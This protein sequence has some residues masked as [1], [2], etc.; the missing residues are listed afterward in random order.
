MKLIFQIIFWLAIAFSAVAQQ[1]LKEQ[2]DFA[3][4]LYENENYFDAV[5]E[6]KRLSYFDSLNSYGYESNY[7]IGSSYKYGGFYDNA[8]RYLRTAEKF[9]KDQNEKFQ[10]EVE[11]VKANILR[12]TFEQGLLLL[13]ELEN[14]ITNTSQLDE[15]NYWRGWAYMLSDQWER[16]SLHFSRIDPDHP[17]KNLADQ[18]ADDKYSVT[19]AK[20][21]SYI[22]PGF[23]Q[24]YTG[25]YISGIMSLGWNI[26][27][28]YLTI[29]AFVE[30]RIFDGVAVGGLLWLR[31]YRGN[32]Q[33]AEKFAEQKNLQIA[34]KALEYLNKN[35]Q[36]KKP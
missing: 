12:R 24:F 3:K 2:Y 35:Y 16:A 29:D 14:K 33:N 20:L 8:I 19:F 10:L 30:D 32:V 15:I 27:L 22:L 6:F 25:E 26:L 9:T 36:G 21:I 31:F 28:G 4:T 23:G 17:L 13:D 18:V 1:N 11:I 5:T 34:N 7:Y